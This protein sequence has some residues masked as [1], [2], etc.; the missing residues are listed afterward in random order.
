M[1]R[2][3]LHALQSGR[4]PPCLLLL[5]RPERHLCHG[6]T[7][8][9]RRVIG[10][11]LSLLLGTQ[12]DEAVVTGEVS[13]IGGVERDK[14]HVLA[15]AARSDPGVILRTWTAAE[16]RRSSQF[17]PLIGDR[18]VV[19]DDRSL[20]DPGIKAFTSGLAPTTDD[21]PLHQLADGEKGQPYT[22]PADGGVD[23]GRS[24]AL[25]QEGRDIG[26]DDNVSH[27]ESGD[28]G[29]AGSPEIGEESVELFV[30]LPDIT[31]EL[32]GLD[33]LGVLQTRQF[34]EV[35]RSDG[36]VLEVVVGVAHD[37]KSTRSGL[38]AIEDIQS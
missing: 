13:E 18:A 14:R 34:V 31:Y 9:L 6:Y 28:R 38:A 16:L 23:P 11:G 12:E 25:L 17:T 36:R 3:V 26:V 8:D 19:G 35:W 29:V 20:G 24:T 15:N 27:A 2:A 32:I 37:T 22:V 21:R 10:T 30:G 5:L 7:G 4:T 33:R 1:P